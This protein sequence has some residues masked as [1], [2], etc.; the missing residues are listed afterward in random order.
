VTRHHHAATWQ[1]IPRIVASGTQREHY[2]KWALNPTATALAQQA[3]PESC[4]VR[5]LWRTAQFQELMYRRMVLSRRRRLGNLSYWEYCRSSRNRHPLDI[6]DRTP[7]WNIEPTR[8]DMLGIR[9][10]RRKKRDRNLG[11]RAE[12]HSRPIL[13][14]LPHALLQFGIAKNEI[15]R[16]II[17]DNPH[18]N[19]VRASTA[20]HGFAT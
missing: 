15:N 5:L 3:Y 6:P 1:A 14:G 10:P 7:D 13:L 19:V 20:V 4:L 16:F 18:A 11:I 9:E 12:K 8:G 2:W 17:T